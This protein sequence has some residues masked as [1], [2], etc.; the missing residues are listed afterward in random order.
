MA[1]LLIVQQLLLKRG[2][3]QEFDYCK[4]E[5]TVLC[6]HLP[7]TSS[8]SPSFACQEVHSMGNLILTNVA[9]FKNREVGVPQKTFIRRHS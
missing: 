7:A 6:G 2:K 9:Q 3:N 5:G 4:N 1:K 8:L